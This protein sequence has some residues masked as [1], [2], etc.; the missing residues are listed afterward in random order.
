MK[1]KGKISVSSRVKLSSHP[2]PDTYYEQLASFLMLS[3]LS[4]K[5][6]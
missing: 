4:V 5:L 3:F 1:N 6:E 2:C